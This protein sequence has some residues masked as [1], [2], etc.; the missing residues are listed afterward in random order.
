MAE[1]PSRKLRESCNEKD[2]IRLCREAK[3]EIDAAYDEPPL[4]LGQEVDYAEVRIVRLRNCLI[5][6]LRA[7]TDDSELA[8]L[9]GILDRVNLALSYVVG[10]E[11]PTAGIHRQLIEEARTVLDELHHELK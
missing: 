5:E 9:K 11:Y 2:L 1:N 8:R 6:R 4:K 3:K 7:E 10:V